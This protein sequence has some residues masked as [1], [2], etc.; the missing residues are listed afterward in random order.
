MT[1][2]TG[3]ITT[4]TPRTGEARNKAGGYGYIKAR[5]ARYYLHASQIIAMAEGILEP[6][7]G[8]TVFFDVDDTLRRTIADL[9]SAVR[10]DVGY[11]AVDGFQALAG[12]AVAQ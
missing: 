11:P 6:T 2:L 12:K 4:W 1:R 8:C 3:T 7:A 9:P 10:V 5:N